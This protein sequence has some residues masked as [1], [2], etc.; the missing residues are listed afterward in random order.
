MHS[1][2]ITIIVTII[3]IITIIIVVTIIA[4][5]TAIVVV[6]IG[7]ALTKNTHHQYAL[8]LQIVYKCPFI[9]A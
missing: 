6:F 1:F 5:S 3:I 2:I 4:P 9:F 7:T 8:R